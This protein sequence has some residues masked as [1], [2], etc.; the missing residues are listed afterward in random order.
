MKNRGTKL[1]PLFTIPYSL[2]F[3][4]LGTHG[5]GLGFQTLGADLEGLASKV[6]GLQVHVAHVFGLDVGVAAGRTCGGTA[7]A[8]VADTH[9]GI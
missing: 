7:A 2:F 8:G 5:L 1:V 4:L 3:T 6:L 9:K